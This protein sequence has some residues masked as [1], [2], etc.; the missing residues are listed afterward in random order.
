MKF[1]AQKLCY[2]AKTQ[3][4]LYEHK[5]NCWQ[6]YIFDEKI[7]DCKGDRSLAEI[8]AERSRYIR[9]GKLFLIEKLIK[10]KSCTT[11]PERYTLDLDT[12]KKDLWNC[13]ESILQAYGFLA[14]SVLNSEMNW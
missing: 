10:K 14:T 8:V 11:H 12:Y 9:F 4:A 1:I 5:R 13:I 6:K 2:S 7:E 3:K